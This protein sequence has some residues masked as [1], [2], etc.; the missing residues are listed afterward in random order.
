MNKPHQVNCCYN[1]KHY[2]FGIDNYDDECRMK[3][4]DVNADLICSEYEREE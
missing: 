3:Q 4:E 2:V 1:C